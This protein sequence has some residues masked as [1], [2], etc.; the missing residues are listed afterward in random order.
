MPRQFD[1]SATSH[2]VNGCR[3]V[4]PR[5][6]P[7]ASYTALARFR[8]QKGLGMRKQN[9]R[10]KKQTAVAG[11]HYHQSLSGDVSV[12]EVPPGEGRRQSSTSRVKGLTRDDREPWL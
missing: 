7:T 9:F 3:V 4:N 12:G 6:I 10:F 11:F 1:E 5:R 8:D 2:K